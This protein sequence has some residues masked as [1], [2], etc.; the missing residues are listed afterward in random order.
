METASALSQSHIGLGGGSS[1][2]PRIEEGGGLGGEE[3]DVELMFDVDDDLEADDRAGA[4]LG[5][6]GHRNHKLR[7]SP[8]L[9]EVETYNGEIDDSITDTYL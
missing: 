2:F 4:S 6:P 9:S 3:L 1:Q 7:L 8:G 5:T